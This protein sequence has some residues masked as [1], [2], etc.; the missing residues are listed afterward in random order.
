MYCKHCGKEI[1]KNYVFC[2]HCRKRVNPISGVVFNDC[3]H[4]DVINAYTVLGYS[5]SGS[6]LIGNLGVGFVIL[7]KDKKKLVIDTIFEDIII[8][9]RENVDSVLVKKNGKWGL[10]NPLKGIIICDF[11]YDDISMLEEDYDSGK[12]EITVYSDDLCGKIDGDGNIILPIIYDEIRSRGR[13]KY[14]GLWG[15]VRN[16]EQIIPCEYIKLGGGDEWWE[17]NKYGI[18]NEPS[19]HKNGKWGVIDADGRISLE[20]EYDEIKIMYDDIFVMRKGDKWGCKIG[21]FRFPCE[22]SLRDIKQAATAYLD[23]YQWT[24]Y[25]ENGRKIFLAVDDGEVS[26]Y[27]Q[28]GN[29][30][31]QIKKVFGIVYC[32][33]DCEIGFP[34]MYSHRY[35]NNI[36]LVGDID[37]YGKDWEARF[38]IYKINTE[39]FYMTLIGEFAAVH[40]EKDGFKV[41]ISSGTPKWYGVSYIHDSYYDVNGREVRKDNTEYVFDDMKYYYGESLVNAQKMVA[42]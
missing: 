35:G 29:N 33:E 19:Q 17:P 3:W 21:N 5:N 30:Q 36:F 16:G 9:G 26:C 10:V 4:N 34:I 15:C 13:V 20:F 25:A 6:Y 11:I 42:L 7:D 14:Q 32:H 22:F 27:T 41:A 31:P 2:W 23:D 1:D 39:N 37:P 28:E 18:E 40:F 24:L 12:G 38:F 8:Q